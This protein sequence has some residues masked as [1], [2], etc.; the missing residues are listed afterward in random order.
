MSGKELHRKRML[1][2]LVATS[3]KRDKHG[4]IKETKYSKAACILLSILLSSVRL[5]PLNL[6]LDRRSALGATSGA[7]SATCS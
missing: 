1:I 3:P 6:Y 2:R 4:S 5:T 7:K